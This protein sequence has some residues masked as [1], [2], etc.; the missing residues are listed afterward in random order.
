MKIFVWQ[1]VDGLTD[2]YHDGGGVVVVA[3]SLERAR[4]LVPA[5]K[6]E[7]D[8]AFEVAGPAVEESLIFPD[9][10]TSV[11]SSAR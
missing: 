4:Q 2:N 1:Y 5:L 11:C 7:P 10:A 3:E 9:G 6:D 8:R